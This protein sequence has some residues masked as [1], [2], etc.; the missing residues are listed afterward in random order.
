M[1]GHPRRAPGSRR[2]H[3]ALG[4]L[5]AVT[6][7]FVAVFLTVTRARANTLKVTEFPVPPP[8]AAPNSIAVGA[9]QAI[10]FTDYAG[11]SVGRFAAGHFT[12]F[13][14]S[15]AGLPGSIVNGPDGAL[16]FADAT[17]AVIWRITTS[18]QLSSFPLPPC[19]GCAYSGGSG[20]GNLIVGPDGALWYSRPGNNAIGRLTTTGAVHEFPIPT[21]LGSVPGWI[22]TGPDGAIWFTVS[23]GIARMTTAGAVALVWNGINYPYAITTG[24]DGNLWFTGRYQDEV[25]RLTP[26]GSAKLF[27][28]ATGCSP[29]DISPGDGTLWVACSG[30]GR[31]YRVSPTGALT[32]ISVP[33][34]TTALSGFAQDPMGAIWFTEPA[35]GRLGRI[36]V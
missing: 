33:S 8:T 34:E 18:G 20:T 14:L 10:W 24:P 9:D 19:T 22:T 1:D 29:L 32:A 36:T 12:R 11:P 28:V 23:D 21:Q 13:P 6:I 31:I 17:N 35:V 25:G 7:V 3:P 2:L 4:A 5:L 27:R 15:I 16:W 26:R 30:L